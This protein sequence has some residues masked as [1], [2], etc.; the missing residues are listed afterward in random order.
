MEIFI[1]MYSF[2]FNVIWDINVV[3]DTNVVW[4]NLSSNFLGE[5]I[6]FIA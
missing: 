3:Q 2:M 4:D 5:K 6:E 1:E